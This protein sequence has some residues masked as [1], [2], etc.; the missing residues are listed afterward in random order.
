MKL[1]KKVLS[2]GL[3]CSKIL[4][5]TS[6]FIS[7]RLLLQWWRLAN[8]ALTIRE[9]CS[10]KNRELVVEILPMGERILQISVKL[11]VLKM[12]KSLKMMKMLQKIWSKI[13]RISVTKV[14]KQ[15]GL[16][17]SLS[18]TVSL[19]FYP[20]SWPR[21]WARKIQ[22]HSVSRVA[23]K[24]SLSWRLFWEFSCRL[25]STPKI[26]KLETRSSWCVNRVL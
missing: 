13:L 1:N 10:L 6:R 9:S 15:T 20:R 4:V 14:L 16:N 7:R 26:V 19:S 18:K 5:F 8:W 11:V 21:N 22:S 12:M 2:I 3:A 23:L 25:V 17:S 24:I